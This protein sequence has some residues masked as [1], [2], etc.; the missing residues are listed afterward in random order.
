MR[1]DGKAILLWAT[2][3]FHSHDGHTRRKPETCSSLPEARCDSHREIPPTSTRIEVARGLSDPKCPVSPAPVTDGGGDF[4]FY[5][6]PAR[7]ATQI[8]PIETG[9]PSFLVDMIHSE[10]ISPWTGARQ[11]TL[12]CVPV[13]VVSCGKRNIPI[14]KD[15]QAASRKGFSF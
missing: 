3:F 13:P 1:R 11:I 14:A 2:M 9:L 12:A 5:G 15:P 6:G 7:P 8:P 10:P 4:A